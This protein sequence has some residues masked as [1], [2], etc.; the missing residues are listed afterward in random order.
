MKKYLS[1]LLIVTVLASM[2][3]IPASADEIEPRYANTLCE[4]CKA[5][6][7]IYSRYEARMVDKAC[8][9]SSV[10]HWHDDIFQIGYGTCSNCGHEYYF[11]YLL[12][13]QCM[14]Y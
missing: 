5:N 6:V 9:A 3:V 2:L 12:E 7:Y 11:E 8:A 1:L 14:I 13:S 4:V 10:P